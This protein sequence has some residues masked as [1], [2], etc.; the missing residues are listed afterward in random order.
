MGLAV[1]AALN[2][3]GTISSLS[4]EDIKKVIDTYDMAE[5]NLKLKSFTMVFGKNGPLVQNAYIKKGINR[6][7]Y[8][9][10]LKMLYQSLNIKQYENASICEICGGR[11]HFNFLDIWNKTLELTGEEKVTEKETGRDV[12]PLIGSIGNDAQALP[13]AS[14]SINIC[15]LC[16]LAVNFLPLGTML[17]KGRLICLETTSEELTVKLVANIVKQNLRNIELN[18]R[19][20]IGGKAGSRAFIEQILN[21]FSELKRVEKRSSLPPHS[22]LNIWQFSNSG[23]GADAALIEIPNRELNLL[24]EI[25]NDERDF[26]EEVLRLIQNEKEVEFLDCILYGNDY[27]LLYPYKKG[28]GASPELYSFYQQKICGVSA[29]ALNT[30]YIIAK[31]FLNEKA[32]KEQEKWL[33]S[34]VFGDVK[35]KKELKA[36]IVELVKAGEIGIEDYS[37]LFPIVSKGPLRVDNRGWK[38]I[39]YYLYNF[40]EVKYI[41]PEENVDLRV[42]SEKT[43][44]RIKKLAELY[45]KYYVFKDNGGKGRGIARFEKDILDEMKNKGE[46]W[47]RKVFFD[48]AKLYQIEEFEF[49]NDSAYDEW[50]DFCCDE[51]GNVRVNELLF[52]LRLAF[53]DLYRKYSKMNKK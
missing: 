4:Y 32:G 34:N 51:N 23:T 9:E 42:T 38:I 17:V 52:Q 2:N 18:K 28:R 7:L 6:K 53:A 49:K 48:I 22:T 29:K 26:K 47:L 35:N 14:R 25:A 37:E 19:E 10:F 5:I 44:P 27:R 36:K 13:S 8:S 43:D 33:K 40:K 21:F 50:N 1:I 41:L 24:W 31:M 39:M 46:N 3:K 15:P 30:A 11:M 20:I 12:F 16:L 45:F